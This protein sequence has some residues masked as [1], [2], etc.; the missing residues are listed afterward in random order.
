MDFPKK[1][2]TSIGLPD[3]SSVEMAKYLFLFKASPNASQTCDLLQPVCFNINVSIRELNW[4]MGVTDCT[5]SAP[6]Y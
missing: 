4:T 6:I 2:P 1:E 3:K 5:P